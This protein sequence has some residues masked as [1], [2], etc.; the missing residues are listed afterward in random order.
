MFREKPS[1]KMNNTLKKGN[2]PEF[3]DTEFFDAADLQQY[4]SLIGS[5]HW[6]KVLGCF[7]IATAVMSMS[8]IYAFPH[9]GHFERLKCKCE[10]ITKIKH[11]TPSFRV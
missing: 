4:Q 2:C 10:Y 7:A 8:S 3:D 6:T 1:D 5:L 11:A 9:R